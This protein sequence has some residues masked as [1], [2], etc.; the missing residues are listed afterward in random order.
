MTARKKRPGCQICGKETPKGRLTCGTECWLARCREAGRIRHTKR[1]TAP[2]EEQFR[3]K[4]YDV[5][6]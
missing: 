2:P 6:I 3:A 5:G 1:P 4:R